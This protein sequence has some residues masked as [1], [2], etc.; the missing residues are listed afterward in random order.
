MPRRTIAI[1]LVPFFLL[2]CTTAF[3]PNLPFKQELVVYGILTPDRNIQI[4]RLYSTQPPGSK[5]SVFTH[6][7]GATITVSGGTGMISFTDT[8][9][10]LLNAQG[11]SVIVPVYAAA[12]TPNPG[13]QYTLSVEAPGIGSAF[14]SLTIP[15]PSQALFLA[16]RFRDPYSFDLDE[17]L[18][19]TLSLSPHTK[20]LLVCI[21]LEYEISVGA[22]W[23]RR[24][25]EVP[26]SIV[27]YNNRWAENALYPSVARTKSTTESVLFSNRVYRHMLGVIWE[28]VPRDLLKMRR[29]IIIVKQVEESL[30]NYYNITNGFSDEFTIRLDKP[31]YSNIVGGAGLFSASTTDSF[32]VSLPDSLGP[33]GRP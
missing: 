4:I 23:E 16:Q 7:S 31:D 20:G 15:H 1:L 32:F 28:G 2:S 5:Q 10:S 25:L 19:I 12:M 17:F 6:I 14:S 18:S 27:N 9:I 11:D 33:P 3:D 13:S 24:T 29:A 26:L 8:T 30:Y 22:G 21:V